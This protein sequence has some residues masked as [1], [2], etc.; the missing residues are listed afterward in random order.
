MRC[1]SL[2]LVLIRRISEASQKVLT[3][4]TRGSKRKPS[5]LDLQQNEDDKEE[6]EKGTAVV[7]DKTDEQK[8]KAAL[9]RRID[10]VKQQVSAL[11]SFKDALCSGESLLS[12]MC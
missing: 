5:S 4:A 7:S 8:E 10:N 3:D 12:F 9:L 1:A 11:L 6:D 2:A